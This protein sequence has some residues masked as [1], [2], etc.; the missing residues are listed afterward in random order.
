MYL[1]F[2]TICALRVLNPHQ[3][4]IAKKVFSKVEKRYPKRAKTSWS[5]KGWCNKPTKLQFQTILTWK[6]LMLSS[7][8]DQQKSTG[9]L[10]YMCPRG[11]LFRIH[12]RKKRQRASNCLSCTDEDEINVTWEALLNDSP[13]FCKDC[14]ILCIHYA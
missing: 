7:A 8:T 14:G 4:S 10:C 5:Q 11:H 1:P 9:K 2:L 12:N 3:W 6:I 13:I